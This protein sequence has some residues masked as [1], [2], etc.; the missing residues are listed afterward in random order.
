MLNEKKYDLKPQKMTKLFPQWNK[1][2]EKDEN[3]AFVTSEH[4]KFWHFFY[5]PSNF[6]K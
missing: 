5:E 3:G 6:F 2:E 4:K 1:Q